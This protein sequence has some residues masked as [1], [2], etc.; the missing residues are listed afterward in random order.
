[1]D[2]IFGSEGVAANDYERQADISREIGLQAALARLGHG[3]VDERDTPEKDA[4]NEKDASIEK[5]NVSEKEMLKG[6][7]Q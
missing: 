7:E 2:V 1:M 5:T 4:S 3:R 6:Q